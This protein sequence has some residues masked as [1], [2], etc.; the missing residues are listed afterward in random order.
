MNAPGRL[1]NSRLPVLPFVTQRKLAA[2]GKLQAI[3][4][5]LW[6][7]PMAFQWVKSGEFLIPTP[8]RG[9]IDTLT[10]AAKGRLFHRAY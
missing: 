2:K 7:L 9:F 10:P 6:A 1:A 3:G 4:K 8:H 5:V